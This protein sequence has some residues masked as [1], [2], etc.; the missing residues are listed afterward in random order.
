MFGEQAVFSANLWNVRAYK[1][2]KNGR[3]SLLS[4]SRFRLKNVYDTFV[5]QSWT[6]GELILRPLFFNSTTNF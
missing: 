1:K 2:K 3:I 5:C 4:E 6:D